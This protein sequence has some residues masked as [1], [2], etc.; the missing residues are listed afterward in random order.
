[1]QFSIDASII[2]K[3][4][5]QDV[6]TAERDAAAALEVDRLISRG[7]HSLQI[8]PATAYDI[9][10]DPDQNRENRTRLVFGKYNELREPPSSDRFS[11]NSDGVTT[12]LAIGWTIS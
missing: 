1:M 6:S 9:Q 2:I 4:E 11:V 7:D 10:R 5:P 3:V 12:A 8:H